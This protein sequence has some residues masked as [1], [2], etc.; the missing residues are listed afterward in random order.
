MD[1]QGWDGTKKLHIYR[2]VVRNR[3]HTVGGL[4]ATSYSAY[5]SLIHL[6]PEALL[7]M[8]ENERTTDAEGRAGMWKRT[9]R[10]GV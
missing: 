2:V 9:K 4:V 6:P 5:I 7:E 3:K 10:N 1:R 8:D